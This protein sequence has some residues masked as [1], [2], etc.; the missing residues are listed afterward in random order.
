LLF[1]LSLD[2]HEA[3]RIKSAMAEAYMPTYRGILRQIA[4]G[5]LVHADETRGVVKGSGHYVWVFANLTT[6]AY[7]YSETREAAILEDVLDGFNGVLVSDFYAAY[8]S[9]PCAQQKCLIHLTR[10]IN[11]HLNRRAIWLAASTD[12]R[13]YRH[14]RPEGATSGQAQKTGR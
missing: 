12:R 3:Y 14:V 5:S 1:D 8:D 11:E 2:K 10:D 9:V 13:D 6:V 4:A 7:V